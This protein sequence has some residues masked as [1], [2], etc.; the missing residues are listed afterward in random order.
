MN[1]QDVI[2]QAIGIMASED[3]ETLVKLLQK[4]GSMVTSM[5]NQNEI[6][7]A[8]FKALKNSASFR[9]DLGNY[10]T[11][12]AKN[13]YSNYGG[14]DFFANASAKPKY[15][16]YDPKTGTGGSGVGNLL[17]TV[18][19]KENIDTAVKAG[20]GFAATKLQSKASKEGEQRAIDYEAAKAATASAEADAAAA[21][22]A[23]A[24]AG[25]N[26]D[27]KKTPKWVLPVAIGGGLLVIGAIV[28]FATRKK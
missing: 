19:T 9:N 12:Q 26:P 17:R 22:K 3:K 8:S 20:I 5:S 14:D 18:F 28:F 21:K 4:S 2:T 13:D 10:L 16:K 15:T 23:A 6:L 7:D 24:E 25:V 11:Q 27:A 1:N